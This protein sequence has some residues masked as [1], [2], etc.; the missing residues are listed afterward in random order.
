MVRV[1]H[2]GW[3]GPAMPGRGK[4]GLGYNLT[5]IFAR[6]GERAAPNLVTPLWTGCT[7]LRF[8]EIAAP[9]SC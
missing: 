9:I 2:S 5:N 6:A 8:K 4:P 3:R 7:G 1:L